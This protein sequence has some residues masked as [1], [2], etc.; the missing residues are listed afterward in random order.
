[1]PLHAKLRCHCLPKP[2]D[3]VRPLPWPRADA[4][5][6]ALREAGDARPKKLPCPGEVV[7]MAHS[8]DDKDSNV[9]GAA[10]GVSNGPSRLIDP[11]TSILTLCD[12]MKRSHIRVTHRAQ[13]QDHLPCDLAVSSASRAPALT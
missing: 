3:S 5:S 4:R 10:E 6:G 8:G 9:A 11:V 1:M 7:H 2:S 13:R 12:R